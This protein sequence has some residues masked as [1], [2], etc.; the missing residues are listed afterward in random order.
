MYLTRVCRLRDIIKY[1]TGTRKVSL[2]V[3]CPLLVVQINKVNQQLT[4]VLS[5]RKHLPSIPVIYE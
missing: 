3:R 2:V 4:D 1:Q 5:V